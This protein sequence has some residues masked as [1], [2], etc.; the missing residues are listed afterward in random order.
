MAARKAGRLRRQ[1]RK[2]K[3]MLAGII[4]LM[5]ASMVAYGFYLKYFYFGKPRPSHKPS[6][7]TREVLNE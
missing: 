1:R 5:V 4:L 2:E 6:T 7:P 3:L